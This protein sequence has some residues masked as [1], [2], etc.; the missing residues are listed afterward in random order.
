MATVG[1]SRNLPDLDAEV[2]PPPAPDYRDAVRY[3][4]VDAC[5]PDGWAC[6]VLAIWPDGTATYQGQPMTRSEAPPPC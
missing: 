3:Y 1:R 6:E 4:V 5:L 2:P